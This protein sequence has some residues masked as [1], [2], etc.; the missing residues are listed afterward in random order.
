MTCALLGLIKFL[1]RIGHIG[2]GGMRVWRVRYYAEWVWRDRWVGLRCGSGSGWEGVGCVWRWDH[3]PNTRHSPRNPL[4]LTI[5]TPT[6]PIYLT[7]S[8]HH[9]PN[10]HLSCPYMPIPS[11]R[12]SSV[13]TRRKCHYGGFAVA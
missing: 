6:Q 8:I 3:Y 7:T 1:R 4:P 9:S 13:L 12:P 5:H 2:V 10:P 11:Q